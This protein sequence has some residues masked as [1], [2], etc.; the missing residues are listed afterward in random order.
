M[1]LAPAA[2][3]A[4]PITLLPILHRPVPAILQAAAVTTTTAAAAVLPT[5]EAAVHR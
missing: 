1:F 2:T 5:A 4:A 3:A